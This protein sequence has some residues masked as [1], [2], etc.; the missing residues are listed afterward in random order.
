MQGTSKDLIMFLMDA[1]KD[2]TW[3]LE[4]YKEKKKRSLNAN[5]YFHKLCDM[6][7]QKLNM[8]MACCKNHLITSYGQIEYIDGEQM[9]YK[10][11][12]PVEYMQELESVHSSC[13][14]IAEENGKEV[15]FYRLYRGSH[16][17]NTAE[18][19]KLIDGTVGECK[20]Q[21]I[22]TET[23]DKIKEMLALWEAYSEKHYTR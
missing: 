5:N 6:L 2:K 3:V 7:R 14:K 18:M 15:Y 12:A 13:V 17:Y 11:N 1:P 4:E 16:T 23:P 21:G 10:T 8:S 20:E 19:A 22:E 9:I